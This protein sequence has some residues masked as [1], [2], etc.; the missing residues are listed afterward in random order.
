MEVDPNFE[1]TLCLDFLFCAV[2][3]VVVVIWFQNGEVTHFSSFMSTF[4]TETHVLPYF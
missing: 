3:S 4:V 2:I 1:L